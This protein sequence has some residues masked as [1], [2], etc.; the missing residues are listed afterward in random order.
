M[1]VKTVF[2]IGAGG[3]AREV[4]WTI[5]ETGTHAFAGFLVS[6]LAR[7][8]PHDSR[9]EVRGDFG[10]LDADAS[11][12]MG[13]GDPRVRLKVANELEQRFPALDWPSFIH[14]SVHHDARSL[15]IGRGVVVC[16]GAILTVNVTLSDHVMVHYHSSISHESRLGR[17][18]V[19]NPGGRVA[20]GVSIGEAVLVG[21]GALVLQ[22][23]GV[24][25]GARVGA[26]A[27]VTRD[28]PARETVVGSP[29]RPLT[30]TPP[31]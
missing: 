21:S 12:V 15:T 26:G 22:Y 9:E 19:V 3:C 24:G 1:A 16:A 7:L 5:E 30:A 8:G 25:D 13:I 18:S 14:P 17:A 11:V 27:V 2:V 31:R 23:R 4:K 10:V 28:V 29:A 6:D 20:G